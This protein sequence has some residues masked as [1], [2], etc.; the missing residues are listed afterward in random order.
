MSDDSE[1][2]PIVPPRKRWDGKS[3]DSDGDTAEFDAA[4][5]QAHAIPMALRREL[6]SAEL[7]PLEARYLRDTVPPIAKRSNGWSPRRVA[8]VIGTAV[9]TGLAVGGALALNARSQAAAAAPVPSSRMANSGLAQRAAKPVRSMN[10]T[11]TTNIDRGA[12]VSP[13]SAASSP[14]DA[15]GE[16]PTRASTPV[17]RP[18]MPPRSRTGRPAVS[19][20]S[21]RIDSQH[22]A[23]TTPPSI[24]ADPAAVRAAPS[25]SSTLLF[26]PQ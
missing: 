11:S 7:P 9:V 23:P 8:A 25:P 26:P 2:T 18:N 12:A 15:G 6:V 20:P 10:S 19:A 4:R 14:R 22:A 24:A 5:L 16:T 3:Y 13:P 17:A 1:R 21:A